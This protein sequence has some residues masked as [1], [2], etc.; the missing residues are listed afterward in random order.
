MI[1]GFS[2][3]S[4]TFLVTMTRLGPLSEGMS[5]MMSIVNKVRSL[6]SEYGLTRE[7][8]ALYV[9]ATDPANFEFIQSVYLEIET[10]TTSSSV[11]AVSSTVARHCGP[12]SCRRPATRGTGCP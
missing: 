11:K 10:L 2:D 6:R 7:K 4:I 12:A 1:S 3:F 9:T 5:Y 8:A